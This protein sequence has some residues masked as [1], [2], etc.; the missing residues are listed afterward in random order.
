MYCCSS[1]ALACACLLLL[2]PQVQKRIGQ[3]REEP[4]E[5]RGG[6]FVL[7]TQVAP[8]AL[9]DNPYGIG[10]RATTHEDL[11]KYSPHVQ[12]GL[13]HLH[14]NILQVALETGWLGLAVWLVWMGLTLCIIIANYKWEKSRGPP[15]WLSYGN[16][17]AF[18]GLMINGLVE[19]NFGDSEI[20]LL[21]CWLMG[22]S[23]VIRLGSKA[24]RR[25]CV[26]DPG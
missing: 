11:L 24:H 19:N 1:F 17:G 21:F 13:D 25:E 23:A 14:N 10:W 15:G 2:V 18:S 20:L 9:M 3:L 12:P 5:H 8:A 7:W 6:R 26:N 4:T 16:F 22:I